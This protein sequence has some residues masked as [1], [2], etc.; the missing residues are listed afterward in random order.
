MANPDGTAP[1]SGHPPQ[2]SAGPQSPRLEPLATPERACC[3]AAQ[4]VA[5]VFVKPAAPGGAPVELLLCGHHLRVCWQALEAAGAAAFDTAGR[6]LMPRIWEPEP[7]DC[8]PLDSP[9]RS[10]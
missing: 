2:R 4:P 9:M 5:R 10:Y 7:A 8:V 1:Q 3:C 6:M